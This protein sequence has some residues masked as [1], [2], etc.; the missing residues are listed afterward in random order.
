[1]LS[2]ASYLFGS[3][4][5]EPK[6][7]KDEN[8]VEQGEDVAME[9]DTSAAGD[10]DWVVVEHTGNGQAPQV[11]VSDLENLLIEHP[12]MSVYKRTGSEGEESNESEAS[13]EHIVKSKRSQVANRP[14]P[15]R[16]RAV[17][18]RVELLAQVT[19]VKHAQ[20]LNQKQVSVRNSRKNLDRSNKIALCG[21]H[22]AR[23]NRSRNTS[24]QKNGRVPQ[25]KQ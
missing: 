13:N 12:S 25:R 16:M 15:R 21:R 18:A 9:M 7:Q 14:S 24:G 3:S 10:K 20:K 23:Q 11:E 22:S 2:W 19:Q 6:Q 1:M 8:Q 5:S 4:S 17:S